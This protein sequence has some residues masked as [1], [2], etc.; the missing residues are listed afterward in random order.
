MQNF[1]CLEEKPDNSILWS[2]IGPF[3]QKLQYVIAHTQEILD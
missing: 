3:K 2:C 1:T